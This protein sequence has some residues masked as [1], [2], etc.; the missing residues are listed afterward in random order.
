VFAGTPRFP[1]NQL[2]RLLGD[3]SSPGYLNELAGD[4]RSR[5][6]R[7]YARRMREA[8]G[9]RGFATSERVKLVI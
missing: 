6:W 7:K 5:P 8:H 1:G 9:P 4:T 2:V 3:S